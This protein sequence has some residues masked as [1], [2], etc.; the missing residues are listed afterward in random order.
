MI[1]E[2]SRDLHTCLSNLTVDVSAAALTHVSADWQE[3]DYV[4]PYNKMYFI[5][6]GEGMLKIDGRDYYPEPGEVYL[7]PAGLSQSYSVT[8]ERTFTKYWCHFTASVGER[9]LFDIVRV[10][11]FFKVA[12]REAAGGMFEALIAAYHGNDLKS[13]LMLKSSM[14][15]IIAWYLEGCGSARVELFASE[16]NSRLRR[17]LGYIEENIASPLSVDLLASV[18]HLQK[19]YFIRAFREDLGL[20]PMKYVNARRIEIGKNLLARSSSSVSE[21]GAL[22]GFG[23]VFHFSRSFKERTGFTPTA[24][25]AMVAKEGETKA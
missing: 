5:I 23:D 6:D 19:N 20:P 17:V 15:S 9:N 24:F 18:A 13:A 2:R 14:L 21:I 11:H 10:P 16:S 7:L 22:T 3:F 25:R 1:D 12:D 8:S 4:T